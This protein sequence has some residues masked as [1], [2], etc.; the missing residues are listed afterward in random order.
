MIKN[1]KK[2]LLPE[3]KGLLFK[4]IFSK[5]PDIFGTFLND[6][7]NL[8]LNKIDVEIKK[9]GFD[10]KYAG[11]KTNHVEMFAIL[12]KTYYVNFIFIQNISQFFWKLF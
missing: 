11:D 10:G 12:N 9:N 7:L 4:T 8:N 2:D 3:N 1:R 5:H 6:M